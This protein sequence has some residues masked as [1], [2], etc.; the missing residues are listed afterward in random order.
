MAARATTPSQLQAIVDSYD[1]FM[2][3][4]DGVLWNG[5]HY[6]R[7]VNPEAP[8]DTRWTNYWSPTDGL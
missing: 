2:F 3:D 5:D 7:F 8:Y 1:T 4:C 6:L